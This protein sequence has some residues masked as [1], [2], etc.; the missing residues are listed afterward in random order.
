MEQGRGDRPAVLAHVIR[1]RAA[2]IPNRQGGQRE[3]A[4]DRHIVP[5]SR[6]RARAFT[7]FDDALFELELRTLAIDGK[8]VSTHSA[9]DELK[10]VLTTLACDRVAAQLTQILLKDFH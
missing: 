2:A 6:E 4:R 10:F 9:D 3:I 7:L 1:L 5:A 8:T